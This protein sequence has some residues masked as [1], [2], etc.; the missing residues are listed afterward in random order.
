MKA[1]PAAASIFC[2]CLVLAASAASAAEGLGKGFGDHIHWR[3]LEDGKKEAAAST[4][5]MCRRCWRRLGFE[6]PVGARCSYSYWVSGSRGQPQPDRAFQQ[7]APQ[8]G[9]PV[10]DASRREVTPHGRPWG[11]LSRSPSGCAG[12]AVPNPY[13]AA[14][15]PGRSGG[16]GAA[17]RPAGGFH[18]SP[19]LTG[20][21]AGPHAM[22][23]PAQSAVARATAGSRE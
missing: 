1:Q 22:A 17:R 19:R 18:A 4:I 3:T 10:P 6:F 21:T 23:A 12:A 5:W 7:D 20:G 2:L 8:D 16:R 15:S 14:P 11:R 13:A 9:V